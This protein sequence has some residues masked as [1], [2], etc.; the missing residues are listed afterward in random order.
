MAVG[1]FLALLFYSEEKKTVFI[2]T[3]A[4]LAES[5]LSNALIF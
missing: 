1:L 2:C 4:D 3:A 5:N